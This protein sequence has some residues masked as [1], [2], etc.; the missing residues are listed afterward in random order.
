MRWIPSRSVHV[1]EKHR[2]FWNRIWAKD[3]PH[4]T[5]N[6]PGSLWNC[7]CGWEETDQPVTDGNPK[8]NASQQGL[9]GNPAITGEI[10]TDRHSYIERQKEPIVVEDFDLVNLQTLIDTD[11]TQWRVDYYTD[12]EGMLL[13]NRNRIK[14]GQ[15]NKRKKKIFDKEWSTS[16]TMAKNGFLV[17]YRETVPGEFDVFLDGIP[18]DLKKTGSA[19]NIVNRAKK[20]VRKQK[21]ELVV[22]EFTA[23]TKETHIEINK[24]REKGIKGYYFFSKDK[25]KIYE[26]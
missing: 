5:D 15:I 22:F 3:D 23:E 2:I 16:R 12:N 17:E 26:L 18:A 7:K 21:A 25:T 1:R 19:G 24:L 6:T 14:E 4:W 20:A 8:T 9:E 10:F 13:T 11:T